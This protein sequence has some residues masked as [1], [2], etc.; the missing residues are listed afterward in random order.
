MK[1]LMTGQHIFT[2]L[3][4]DPFPCDPFTVRVGG[5]EIQAS[6]VGVIQNDRAQ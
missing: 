1:T 3:L 5:F 2:D 4:V 6:H